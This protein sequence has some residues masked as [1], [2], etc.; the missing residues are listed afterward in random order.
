MHSVLTWFCTSGWNFLYWKTPPTFLYTS[1]LYMYSVQLDFVLLK[2][3]FFYW[4]APLTR[5]FLAPRGL[6]NSIRFDF[7][8]L[9]CTIYYK[10]TLDI[11]FGAFQ[12]VLCT[13][14]FCNSQLNFFPNK[15]FQCKFSTFSLNMYFH[16]SYLMLLFVTF[17]SC[18][19]FCCFFI[20][21]HS[22]SFLS[23]VFLFL[24]TFFL[25]PSPPLSCPLLL[26]LTITFFFFS[27]LFSSPHNIIHFL[28]HIFLLLQ[29]EFQMYPPPYAC[30]AYRK[31]ISLAF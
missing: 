2:L 3:D 30:T 15:H 28:I 12:V 4:K 13:I 27:C 9:D 16:L 25:L 10:I 21:S 7:V 11:H 19:S 8:L 6:A 5:F 31:Q 23:F 20:Y 17:G 1:V 26:G 14:I 22:V 18:H 24:I 29:K